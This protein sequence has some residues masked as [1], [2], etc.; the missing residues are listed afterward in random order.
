MTCWS[1][2]TNEPKKRL[3][4]PDETRPGTL[5]EKVRTART[6]SAQNSSS[7]PASP[8]RTGAGSFPGLTRRRKPPGMS[9]SIP[10]APGLVK[11]L[12]GAGDKEYYRLHLVAHNGLFC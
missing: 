11:G 10:A 8:S 7:C 5:P 4:D 3:F 1:L 9:A 2:T 12:S 6:C